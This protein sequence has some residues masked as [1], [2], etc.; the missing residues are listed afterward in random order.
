MRG[1]PPRTLMRCPIQSGVS[2]R[3]RLKVRTQK[4]PDCENQKSDC[5][6]E[7]PERDTV[8]ESQVS[9]TAKSGVS[10]RQ[11]STGEDLGEL[12]ES[13]GS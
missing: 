2:H 4:C 9:K 1:V 7:N 11:I 6:S 8:V 12:L 5:R 3:W 10:G 13:F